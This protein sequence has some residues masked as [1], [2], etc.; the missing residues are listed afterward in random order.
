MSES[1]SEGDQNMA[2]VGHMGHILRKTSVDIAQ[3]IEAIEAAMRDVRFS[4]D[5]KESIAAADKKW[6]YKMSMVVSALYTDMLSFIHEESKIPDYFIR[7]EEGMR[8]I[9]IVVGVFID[10]EMMERE[11]N[12][13]CL[14]FNNV[15]TDM[16]EIYSSFEDKGGV[17]MVMC[18]GVVHDLLTILGELKPSIVAV[19]KWCKEKTEKKVLDELLPTPTSPMKRRRAAGSGSEDEE[20]ICK[21]FRCA[22]GLVV[23]YDVREMSVKFKGRTYQI[24]HDY[25]YYLVF[26]E[27]TTVVAYE[28]CLSVRYY[29]NCE[30]KW[31]SC[32]EIIKPEQGC[33]SGSGS[34]RFS[35]GSCAAKKVAAVRD[36][37]RRSLE[38]ALSKKSP[39]V[40]GGEGGACGLAARGKKA[41]KKQKAAKGDGGCG[42]DASSI[43]KDSLAGGSG[44]ESDSV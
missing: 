33:G 41:A 43:G 7:P 35:T 42:S 9:S 21:T 2:R 40:C 26:N 19:A 38:S 20:D 31:V 8:H 18:V 28:S 3:F 14:R 44:S 5:V 32:K 24:P 39:A 12:S 30:M 6:C 34:G 27:K 10:G 29:R 25:E 36:T 11:L 4:D 22:K 16:I 1:D 23:D 37:A 13:A 15:I 17:D